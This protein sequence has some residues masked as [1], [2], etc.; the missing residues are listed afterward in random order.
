MLRYWLAGA[1]TLA[2]VTNVASAQVTSSETT[3]TVTRPAVIVPVPPPVPVPAPNYSETRTQRT[4]DANG[5]ETTRSEH[6]D[7]SQT[8][9]SGDG[10]LSAETHVRTQGETTVVTP[11]A[12][13]TYR[14]TTTTTTTKP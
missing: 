11:P 10:A 12:V 9:T 13:S 8:I 1:A 3:T 5:V 2:L 4:I 6:V 14:S 7:K